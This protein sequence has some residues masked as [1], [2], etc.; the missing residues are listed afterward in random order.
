MPRY[1]TS[2]HGGAKVTHIGDL[3]YL[4]CGYVLGGYFHITDEPPE[5]MRVCARCLKRQTLIAEKKAR[6][7]HAEASRV[8]A[9]AARDAERE[10]RR[11]LRAYGP[12]SARAQRYDQRD[13]LIVAAL[14]EGL[15]NAGVARRFGWSLRTVVR[16]LDAAEKRAG[17]VTRFRWGYVVGRNAEAWERSRPKPD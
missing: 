12:P 5:G 3:H 1:V 9:A 11:L 4:L 2:D 13:S 6:K 10:A 15:D 7:V 14:I 8:A 17:A 16:H